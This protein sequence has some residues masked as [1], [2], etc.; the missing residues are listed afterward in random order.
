MCSIKAEFDGDVIIPTETIPVKEPYEAIVAF[1][2]PPEPVK[3]VDD[4]DEFF[5]C[6]RE[7]SPW[8][9]DSVEIIRKMRDEW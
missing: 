5:G 9:G 7:H 8:D 1:T 3:A 6:F 2:S 4:L